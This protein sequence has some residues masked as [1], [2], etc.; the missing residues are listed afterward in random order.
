MSALSHS[1]IDRGS[2]W[3][4]AQDL[5][6]VNPVKILPEVKQTKNSIWERELYLYGGLNKTR[7]HTFT[8]WNYL[9]PVNRTT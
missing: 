9:S 3:L 1:G 7:V 4:P 8:Y 5:H 2:E 6:K